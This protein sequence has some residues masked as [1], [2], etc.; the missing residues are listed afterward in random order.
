MPT[1]GPRA[2]IE[3]RASRRSPSVRVDLHSHVLPGV[4]DGARDLDEALAMLGIAA[5]DGTRVIVATP[6]DAQCSREQVVAGVAQLNTSVVDAGL[7]ITVVAGSEVFLAADLAERYRDGQVV[8][9]NETSS[10][11]LELPLLADWP[12]FLHQAIFDLQMAGAM[13][14]LAHAERYRA[15]QRQPH[16]LAECIAMGIPIQVNA[17][18]LCGH[19]G[20]AAQRTA[21]ELVRCR[22]AHVIASDAHDVRTRPPQLGAA[23]ARVS[24]VGDADYAAWMVTVAAMLLQGQP[25]SLPEPEFHRPAAGFARLRRRGRP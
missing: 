8:T 1:C 18:S 16:I 12:P 11:L 4:D 25:V 3:E 21:E 10:L 17:G 7:A 9:L 6:H 2:A 23:L 19:L 24:A 14:I 20:R 15:V 13:P 22:L 5:A